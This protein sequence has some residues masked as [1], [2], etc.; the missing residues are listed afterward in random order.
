MFYF[1][2]LFISSVH[3]DFDAELLEFNCYFVTTYFFCLGYFYSSLHPE[4][5]EQ[6][7]GMPEALKGAGG[8]TFFEGPL[9][10]NYIL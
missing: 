3:T 10:T 8:Q 6:W 1:V 4:F 2:Y 7:A 5:E 9:T